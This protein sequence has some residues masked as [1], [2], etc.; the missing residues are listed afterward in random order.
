MASYDWP[1][2]AVWLD[3]AADFKRPQDVRE[4]VNWSRRAGMGIV[5]PC[6]AHATGTLCY[7]SE[8]A[9]TALGYREWNPLRILLDECHAAGIEVHPWF[10]VFCWGSNLLPY[11]EGK[12]YEIGSTPPLQRSHPDWFTTDLYG[13]HT[14]EAPSLGPGPGG[15]TMLDPGKVEVRQ[16]LRHVVT[17]LLSKY[18]DV[19]GIHLDY[20]R[21]EDYRCTL[22]LDVTDAPDIG[23]RIKVGDILYITRPHSD[24]PGEQDLDLFYELTA[25]ST[26]EAVLERQ[27]RYCYCDSCLARFSQETGIR[28]PDLPDTHSVARWLWEEAPEAWVRWRAQQVTDAVR[29]IAGPVHAAHKRLSAA[30][31]WN[32]PAIVRTIAQDWVEWARE[33]LLDFAVPMTYGFAAERVG[34]LTRGYVQ[35]VG[36]DCPVYAGVLRNDGYPLG[37]EELQRYEA[38]VSENGG[39]GVALFCYGTWRGVI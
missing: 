5:F 12:A 26:S 9:P 18:P 24:L 2:R 35:L 7:E 15:L 23:R 11:L 3:I 22:R 6:I 17:E 34:E 13:R 38:L 33:G 16:F 36:T 21:Y 27:Y 39:A 25:L 30:V 28:I 37:G 31:F 14:L 1:R 10:V 19:D 20:I 29:S 8:Y 4:F 32:Y